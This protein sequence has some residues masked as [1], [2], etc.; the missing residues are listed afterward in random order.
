MRFKGTAVQECMRHIGDIGSLMTFVAAHIH[1]G[2]RKPD[3]WAS[4]RGNVMLNA[5]RAK[6]SQAPHLAMSLL[7][8]GNAPLLDDPQMIPLYSAYASSRVCPSLARSRA[9]RAPSLPR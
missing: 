6:F 2:V 8:T 7:A 9:R 5:L 4:V 3:E 1:D